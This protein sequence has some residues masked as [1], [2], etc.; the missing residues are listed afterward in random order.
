MPFGNSPGKSVSLAAFGRDKRLLTQPDFQ[1]VFDTSDY[2]VSSRH[3]LILASHN[4]QGVPRL[5]LVIGKRNCRLAVSRNKIKRLA[6][7]SF[8]HRQCS[9]PTVDI[10]FLA[11]RELELLPATEFRDML[12]KAW[13]KLEHHSNQANGQSDKNDR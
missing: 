7:E 13:Q 11:R 3:F 10:I 1:R 2:R 8:R 5:G 12:A 4:Q 9:L 6:R